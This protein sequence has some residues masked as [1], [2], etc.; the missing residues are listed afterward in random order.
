MTATLRRGLR[1]DDPLAALPSA[2][3]DHPDHAQ[4]SAGPWTAEGRLRELPLE[5]IRANPN[6]P[7]KRVDT[8]ALE[9]LAGS[10]RER[11]ILQ[12]VIVRPVE[13]RFE[14]VA[15]ERRWRAA[16]EPPPAPG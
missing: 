16:R 9:A 3:H 11:G 5:Q 4:P 12:P 15:G 7:R 13:D 10:I 6:Q 14:L 8:D 2:E 1:I